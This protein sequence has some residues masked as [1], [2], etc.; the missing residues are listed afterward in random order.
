MTGDL[1]DFVARLELT[2]GEYAIFGSG[3]IIVRGLIPFS[4]D[5][6]IICR[7]NTWQSLLRN[8]QAEFLDEYD[9]TVVSMANGA[10]TFGSTWGIGKFDTDAL[11]ESAETISGL[12]F[13]QL[14]YV[15]EYKMI[16]SMPKDLTH[17]EAIRS[18]GL[19]DA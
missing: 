16:R 1:F 9:A 14:R 2:P 10:V 17:L 19:I 3:P 8:S 6:D 7:G 13:V 18:A 12:P 4:N 5:L 15:I 11:I